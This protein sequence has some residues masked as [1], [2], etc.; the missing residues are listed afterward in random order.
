[1]SKEV[2]ENWEMVRLG[3]VLEYEQPTKYIV[4]SDNYC[5]DYTTPVLTAGKSFVLGYTSE[6]DNIFNK[7]PVII[8]DDFTTAIKYVDFPF[9]VKSSAMK[10]L[11]PTQKVNLKYIYYLMTTIN[12]DTGLH[13]RYWISIFSDIQIPF[14][15]LETQKQ[16]ANELDKITGLIAKRKSQIEKLDLLV[17]AKFTEMFGDPVTNPKGWEV[18][19]VIT[20]C[21]CMVPGRDKPKSFTGDIPWITIDDLIING[22]TEKS[23]KGF[24]LTLKEINE[25]NRKTIPTGSVIMSCVG[26][27][28]ICSIA[29][30][31]MIINQQLHSFQCKERMNNVFLMHYLGKRKDYMNSKASSTTVLYMNKSICNSIPTILPPLDLQNQ[32]ADYVEKVEHTKITMQQGL[33]QLETLYK[34]KMQTYFE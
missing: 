1:M 28:G 31:P 22:Y 33:T 9:K 14:P 34:Q 29:K 12:V 27:L 4:A 8:F 32:F 21:N 13:K 20:Y 26:N 11:I 24:A 16:I 23:K 5:D 15:P 25:V 2:R 10:I 30:S 19:P 6:Q 7:L 17:K 3:D 18:N